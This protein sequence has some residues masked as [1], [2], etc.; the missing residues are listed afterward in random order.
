MRGPPQAVR[1]GRSRLVAELARHPRDGLRIVEIPLVAVVGR[2]NVGKSTLFNRLVGGHN[3]IVEDEP[4]VTRDRR[5]GNADW[6]GKA[7]RVVDTGGLDLGAVRQAGGG[8]MARL[9]LQQAMKAVEEASLILFVVDAKDGLTPADHE[10]AE[11]LR[12]TGKPVLW[13]A[14]KVDGAKQE[15]LLGD[16]YELGADEVIG[17]S[18][19]HGRNLADLCDAILLRLPDAPLAMASEE[20]RPIRVA[21][22]GRPNAGK[23]SLVNRLVGDDRVIVDATPGTTRD[24]VDTPLIFE[25]RR[26]VLID[27]AGIRRRARVEAP[28]EKIAVAMAE[29]SIGRCDVA[30]LVIDAAGGVAEQEA[31]IA[32][33]C[34]E[35]GR[36]LILTF[37]KRDLVDAAAEKK[38]KEALARQL[39]FVPWA[40]VAFCSALTGRGVRE[41][42]RTVAEVHHNHNRRVTTGELNRFFEGLVEAH[43]PSLYRGHPVRLYYVTQATARPPTFVIQVNHPEGIH[44][45]YARYLANRLREQFGFEGTPIRTIFRKRAGKGK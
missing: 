4:G 22:V 38:L 41:L 5:Y 8:N 43:P 15:A 42:L 31:K 27:T 1:A 20:A 2:P 28:M 9:V 17:I 6:D 37:N 11:V 7:F 39:Q 36:G 24:P 45:S 44:F 13:V 16:L 30:V 19:T 18:A 35:A 33:M 3:A 14:N 26:Y 23:S 40:K 25:D 29:K 10:A 32:G 21:L 34:D 12:K